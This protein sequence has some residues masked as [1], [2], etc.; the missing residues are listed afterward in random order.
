M[1]YSLWM[2]GDFENDVISRIF[3]VFWSGFF[4]QKN[5]SDL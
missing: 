5:K 2:M 4:A 1:G 3:T